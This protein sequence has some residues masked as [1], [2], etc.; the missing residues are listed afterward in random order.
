MMKARGLPSSARS[1]ITAWVLFLTLS[2]SSAAKISFGD[3]E[4]KVYIVFTDHPIGQD[5]RDY[6]I[7]IISSVLGSQEAAEEALG[8][9]YSY[10]GP[11]FSARLTPEQAAQLKCIQRL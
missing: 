11:G 9:V 8:Y 6:A 5:L 4:T 1:N 3:S 2:F 7:Q 10:V